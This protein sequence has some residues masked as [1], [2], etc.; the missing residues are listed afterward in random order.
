MAIG[1]TLAR[2]WILHNTE[3]VQPWYA[4]KL[5]D[6]TRKWG[7]SYNPLHTGPNVNAEPGEEKSFY[8]IM[9]G[10]ENGEWN[11]VKGQGFRL[12]RL[13]DTD[14]FFGTG[15]AIKGTNMLRAYDWAKLGKATV[16]N[17]SAKMAKRMIYVHTYKVLTCTILDRWH[18]WPPCDDSG[19]GFPRTDLHH[20]TAQ[21]TVV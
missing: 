7:D 3:E 14:K 9:D 16:V 11:G 19:I 13:Y 15:G 8:Q 10:D 20:P 21:V 18:H 17:V 1:D 6:A 12:R 5:V 4:N 2:A